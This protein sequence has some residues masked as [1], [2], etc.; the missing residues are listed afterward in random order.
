MHRILVVDDEPEILKILEEFL[1]KMGFE[2]VTALGGERA[3]EIL[4]SEVKIDLAVLD[5]KMPQVKGTDV[6]REMKKINKEIPVIILTGSI[7]VKKYIDGLKELGY[8]EN[9]IC[10]KPVDLYALL[11]MVKKKLGLEPK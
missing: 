10:Y 1:A 2:A 7:D 8:N 4:K 9:D 11:S 6:L 5:M 3:I